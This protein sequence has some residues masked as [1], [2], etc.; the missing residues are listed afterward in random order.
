M[1]EYHKSKP[2]PSTAQVKCVALTT[3]AILPYKLDNLFIICLRA[4]I[5]MVIHL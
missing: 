5:T 1:V 4:S 2:R 3:S